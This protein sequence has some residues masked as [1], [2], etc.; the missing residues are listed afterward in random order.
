MYN[1][2]DMYDMFEYVSFFFAL[3]L[4]FKERSLRM[5]D[6][7]TILLILL[8]SFLLEFDPTTDPHNSNLSMNYA[9]T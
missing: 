5:R 9:I 8:M 4:L 6:E 3:L 2:Y 1:M 7:C